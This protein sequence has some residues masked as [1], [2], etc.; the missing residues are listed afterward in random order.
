MKNFALLDENN[1]VV[2]ISIGD[3]DWSSPGWVAYTDSNPAYI[4]GDYFQGYFYPPQPF[5]S[6]TRDGHGHWIAPEPMPEGL[7][8][9]DEANLDWVALDS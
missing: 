7:Y 3:D 6:W 9:W 4:G 1:I 2:N 5:P 8:R